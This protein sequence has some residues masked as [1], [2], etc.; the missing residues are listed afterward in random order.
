MVKQQYSDLTDI[1][2]MLLYQDGDQ[3]AFNEIYLRH[4]S[5][6]FS[7]LERRI[8]NKNELDD[9]YQKVFVKFHRSRHLYKKKYEVLPW[10]YTIAR[11]ELLDFFKKKKV[12]TVEFKEDAFTQEET[13]IEGI[14]LHEEKNLSDKERTAIEHRYLKDQDFEEISKILETSQSNVRK[15]ISRGLAKLR[16]K[17][18]GEKA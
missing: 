2:L 10:L 18:K 16:T 1:E 17:Y 9:V 3:L 5:R 15:I 6:V 12:E 11:S 7:Y 13:K 4:N 14:D 8:H